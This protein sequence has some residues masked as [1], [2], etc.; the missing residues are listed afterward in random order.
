M[1]EG[2]ALAAWL[3]TQGVSALVS[4]DSHFGGCDLPL[5]ATER[6]GVDLLLSFG[7]TRYLSGTDDRVAFVPLLLLVQPT[8]EG[9][10]VSL[11]AVL[12]AGPRVVSVAWST[13]YEGVGRRVVS[14]LS[15]R[16]AVVVAAP[17]SRS[18]SGQILGCD[19]VGLGPA[20]GKVDAH[21]LVADAFHATGALLAVDGPVLWFDPSGGVVRDITPLRDSMVERRLDDV[22]AAKEARHVGILVERRVGQARMGSAMRLKTLIEEWGKRVTLLLVSDVTPEKLR[23]FVPPIDV[24]VNTACQRIESFPE[25][26]VRILGMRE[27]LAAIGR[28][29]SERLYPERRG[30]NG[31][32]NDSAEETV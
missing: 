7:H 9:L 14:W 12:E 31:C 8:D 27:A 4:T 6:L 2:P 30:D 22:R 13:E 17:G 21:L 24:F 25:Q 15:E 20:V 5:D 11:G 29:P 28:I 1:D 18:S 10:D 32:S 23:R 16:I 3:D 19:Y 26:G